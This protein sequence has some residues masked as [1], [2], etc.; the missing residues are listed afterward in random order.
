LS[1]QDSNPPVST[2]GGDDGT[3]TL[4]GSGRMSK[5]DLRIIVVGDLDE[6]SSFLGLA[7]A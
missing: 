7:R 1:D 6:A 5:D 4:L 2:G 3:T